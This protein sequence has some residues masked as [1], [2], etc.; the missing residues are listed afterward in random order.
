MGFSESEERINASWT[1]G[2]GGGAGGE[3]LELTPMNPRTGYQATIA[4]K[5]WEGNE[6]WERGEKFE[7][8]DGKGT[9]VK[10]VQISQFTS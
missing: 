2:N 10:T 6:E 9:I 5:A 3:Q 1:N 7:G 8:A 4:T